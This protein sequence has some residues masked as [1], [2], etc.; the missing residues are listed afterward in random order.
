MQLESLEKKSDSRGFL[1]EAF[2]ELGSIVYMHSYPDELRGNHYHLR[3]VEKFICVAGDCTITSKDR[4]TGSIMKVETCAEQPL[5]ISVYP[6]NTHNI[7]AG[8]D[9]CVIL[10]WVSEAFNPDD[11]DTYQ[12]EI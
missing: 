1:V 7:V 4:D 3:K 11:P 9:G 2:S 12:E 6:N 5:Q 8:V 10:T